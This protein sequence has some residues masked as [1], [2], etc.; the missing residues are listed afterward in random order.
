MSEV[1]VKI[2][3]YGSEAEKAFNQ[4]VQN[5]K[6]TWKD[7]VEVEVNAAHDGILLIKD[8][9]EACPTDQACD[10]KEKFLASRVN[11]GWKIYI[12]R[13]TIG[14]MYELAPSLQIIRDAS[15]FYL[16][17]FSYR[18]VIRRKYDWEK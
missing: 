10:L 8:T 3:G 18:L 1:T 5:I 6:N 11:K 12:D 14:G 2:G 17:L 4:S 15:G 13:Y 7:K 16:S 9:L